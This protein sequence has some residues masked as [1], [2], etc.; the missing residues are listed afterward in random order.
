MHCIV[1]SI[2]LVALV[3]MLMAVSCSSN[4]Y[5][6]N[7]DYPTLDSTI[8]YRGILEE[9]EH[10]CSVEGPTKRRMLVYLPE[11]YYSSEKRYPVFYLL[12]GAR[13]NELSWIEK[14]NLLHN[15][16]SLSSALRL[17]EMIVVLPNVN[18]YD[19]DDDFGKSR[20][21]GAVESLFET[22]GRVEAAFLTDVVGTID[23]RYRTIADKEHRAIAGLSIGAMQAMHISAN[24]PESF[25]Y[26]A[27]FSSMV[28]PVLRKSEHSAFYKGLHDKLRV[29][30]AAPPELY[31]IMIGKS[32]FYYPRMKS[33]VRHL[34]RKGYN[35]DLHIVSGG[36]QWYNWEE[37]ANIIMQKL[38]IEKSE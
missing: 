33:Y 8:E 31:S 32:D 1:R 21:K 16:D 30:F 17:R 23:S 7:A 19:D 29:Q 15:I 3:A 5:I 37:F 18:Q 12:H 28:H 25:G 4:R 13:G 24:A 27:L 6:A 22:D 38:F 10:N 9:L 35:Y 11:E 26:V 36:H 14:G 34:R 20:I 2:R